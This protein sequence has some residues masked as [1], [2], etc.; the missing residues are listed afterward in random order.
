MMQ[1]LRIGTRGSP[2]ALAQARMVATALRDA[3]GWGPERIEIVPIT[4]TGDII[5]DRPLAEVGGKALWT[6]ELDRALAEGLTDVSVHSMKDV[7]TVR[8]RELAIAAMLPR[9]DVRDRLIGAE[10][11]DALPQSARV[12]TSSPRRT[13]QL[14]ARRPDLRIVPLRGNVETRL[15]KIQLGEADATLLASAGLE[16]LGHAE[17]VVLDDFL[18]APA[19]G[20]I[21]VEV[22]ADDRRTRAL[23]H[24]IDHRATYVC[25]TAERRLLER[26]GGTCHSAVAA[27]AQMDRGRIHLRAEILATDGSEFQAGEIVYTV[28]KEEERPGELAAELLGRASPALRHLFG[29]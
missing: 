7:E 14:L 2:L 24:D 5:R 25:V 23:I 15:R 19:Q 27:L 11:L 13:A 28:A 8:P 20:A 6:K 1:T 22:R 4:T 12:G 3:H 26:L 29:G 18:P 21:G 10:S 17:G 16:R 9:A